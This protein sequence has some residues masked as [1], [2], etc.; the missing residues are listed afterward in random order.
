M[1][2]HVVC[3]TIL[4]FSSRYSSPDLITVSALGIRCYPLSIGSVMAG[5]CAGDACLPW[6]IF[7]VRLLG[8]LL[9]R[10]GIFCVR[11]VFRLFFCSP[12]LPFVSRVLSLVYRF[13]AYISLGVF[14]S[15]LA[16]GPFLHSRHVEMEI[17]FSGVCCHSLMIWKCRYLFREIWEFH[18]HCRRVYLLPFPTGV[19]PGCAL[20]PP[21]SAWRGDRALSRPFSFDQ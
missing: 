4:F 3:I 6:Q 21:A 17:S 2:P 11:L 7:S 20:S 16:V 1:F 14:S 8:L 9:F 19:F 15:V 18:L 13:C 12:S 10:L 5:L